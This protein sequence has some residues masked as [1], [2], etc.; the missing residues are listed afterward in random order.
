M[1]SIRE[2]RAAIRQ[3]FGIKRHDILPYTAWRGG[4]KELA[5]LFGKV[6][7]NVGAEIGVRAARFSTVLLDKNPN[8]K[9]YCVDPW[10]EYRVWGETSRLIVSKAKQEL[11]YE[12][13]SKKLEKRNAHIIRKPSLEAVSN[14]AD[15][16]LDFVYIDAMHNFDAVMLDILNWVPKV[17]RG[18]I[19][20]CHDYLHGH[21]Q[22]VVYAVDAYIRGHGIVDW[23]L[24]RDREPTAFWINT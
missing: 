6:G 8:L 10:Q 11:F 23:Y 24:T 3:E 2:L 14:F 13:A 20:A 7:F 17:K 9:L 12:R 5:S 22:G 15:N 18:G 19:I 21:L 16:M 4:R 1:V